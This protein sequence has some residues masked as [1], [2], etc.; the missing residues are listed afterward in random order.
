[1]PDN[2][3]VSVGK[4]P[5]FESAEVISGRLSVEGVENRVVS[6]ME[7]GQLF[8]GL[9]EYAVLVRPESLEAA[10][11]VLSEP[12]ISDADLT[13]LALKDP[14]PDDFDSSSSK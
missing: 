3:W 12:P 4:Y 1:M 2:D 13:E 5:D 14:P 10:R 7:G 8:G 9:G 6:A 11:Q